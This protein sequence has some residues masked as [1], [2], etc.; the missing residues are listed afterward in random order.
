MIDLPESIDYR[1]ARML[2]AELQQDASIG[3]AV[4]ADPLSTKDQVQKLQLAAGQ[5]TC[6]VCVGVLPPQALYTTDDE[7]SAI[8]IMEAQLAVYILTTPNLSP[9][10]MSS[11]EHAA[12]VRGAVLARLSQWRPQDTGISYGLP[13]VVMMMSLDT[14]IFEGLQNLDGQAIVIAKRVSYR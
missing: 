11:G 10:G 14:T 3:P 7:A 6:A 4:L 1:L 5:Y 9:D 2:I 12:R 8:C 13:R